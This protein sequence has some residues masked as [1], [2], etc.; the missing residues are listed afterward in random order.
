MEEELKMRGLDI[1][2]KMGLKKG[3]SEDNVM[4]WFCMYCMCGLNVFL[5]CREF[6]REISQNLLG[7]VKSR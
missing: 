5:L 1:Y 3:R 2:Y 7:I 4:G 6:V